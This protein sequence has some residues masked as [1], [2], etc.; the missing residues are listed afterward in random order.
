MLFETIVVL[1]II[2][3][4]TAYYY[5]QFYCTAV[6]N[7]IRVPGPQPEWLVGNLRKTG[8]TSG[9]PLHEVIKIFKQQYGDTFSFWIGP[10]YAIVLSRLEHVQH[11]LMDRQTYDMSTSTTQS[12]GVLFPNGLISLRGDAWKRHA[13]FMLP[14]F[15]RAKVL[16]YLDTIV[17]CIDRFIDDRFVERDGQ[18]H[19]DL[20]V[21]CQNVLLNIL[22]FIAFDYDLESSSEANGFNLQKAFNDFVTYA[23]QFILLAGIPMWL[24]KLILSFSWKY[25]RALRV[26][27]HYVMNIITEEQKRQQDESIASNRP[28]NLIASL[29][30]SIKHES[31]STKAFL[32]PEEVFDEVSL[33]TLA[34]FETTSTALSWFI[35]YMSKY[36]HVQQK[37]KDELRDNH[38]SSDTPLTQD[39]LDSLI[40]TECVVK[41][42]LRCAPIAPGMAREA[43]RDD[44]IGDIPIKK[45]DLIFIATQNL[46]QDPRYWKV[47][48]TQFIPER[49]LNEDK[50]PPQYTYMP[51]GG[52]HRACAGQ[53]LAFF[54]LKVAITRLM[55]RVTFEDPGDEAN[56][57]GGFIQR[58]TCLPKHL[59]VRVRI[60]SNRESD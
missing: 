40:Y 45:G 30:S 51:F 38:L 14:M 58:I 27:K 24:G 5:Y 25:Q 8:I 47:D 23:N 33:S 39:L 11:V 59:A 48:P 52:G 26:M 21:Q 4:V 15:K 41:E 35:F 56:N 29:V 16:P 55:Q 2:F 37:M 28:K 42:V 50:N 43:T 53:D 19:T 54:E 3:L 49:F 36:P 9:R 46:H 22:A 12:M 44:I 34:G 31:S 20:V 32:T 6:K 17:T 18:I 57:T 10:Y 60:D 13:R 7:R 1:V